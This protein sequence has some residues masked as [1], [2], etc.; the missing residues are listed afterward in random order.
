MAVH[1]SVGQHGSPA[2]SVA[3]AQL[4]RVAGE[5]CAR[6]SYLNALLEA[7]GRHSG[8]D[9]HAVGGF[10]AM[11]LAVIRAATWPMRS[12]CCAISTAIIPD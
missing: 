6:H 2:V 5:G 3:E 9:V 11:A 8:R 12:T 7:S 1:R 4:A 10:C